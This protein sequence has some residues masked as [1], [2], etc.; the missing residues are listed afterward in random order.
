MPADSRH[1][2]GDE[3]NHDD[4]QHDHGDHERHSSESEKRC[5]PTPT[6]LYLGCE[7]RRRLDRLGDGGFSTPVR[8]VDIAESD[9]RSSAAREDG[10]DQRCDQNEEQEFRHDN[11]TANGDDEQDEQQQP[12][13]SINLLFGL[14]PRMTPL[15]FP[16]AVSAKRRLMSRSPCYTEPPR[17][18]TNRTSPVD[19]GVRAGT[20]DALSEQ[21]RGLF[22]DHARI[23]SVRPEA[24]PRPR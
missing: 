6:T 15:L 20:R 2:V 18:Q 9:S 21:I 12:E 10:H 24:P 16:G 13:H 5:S 23:E 3:R 19:R 22:D 4:E 14:G 7:I 11:S 17:W 8:R 1:V